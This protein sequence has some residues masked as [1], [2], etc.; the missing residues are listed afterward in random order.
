MATILGVCETSENPQIQ[1]L[2]ISPKIC[3]R[4]FPLT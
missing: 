3:G 4:N 2:W 1:N